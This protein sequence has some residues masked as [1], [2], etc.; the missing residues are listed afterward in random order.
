MSWWLQKQALKRLL[1]QK[2]LLSLSRSL[3]LAL[4]TTSFLEQAQFL[5]LLRCTQLVTQLIP[6]NLTIHRSL[7][8]EY[9]QQSFSR[10]W[11]ALMELLTALFTLSLTQA[12]VISQST[13]LIDRR[14]A[15]KASNCRPNTQA[16]NTRILLRRLLTSRSLIHVQAQHW[17]WQLL[18]LSAVQHIA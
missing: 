6:S 10:S 12:Q 18:S 14:L 8:M 13:R 5:L 9:A 4:M 2:N 15:R 17:L 11:R 1:L 3:I 16:Q 7:T